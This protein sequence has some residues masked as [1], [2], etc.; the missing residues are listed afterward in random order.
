MRR[1][2]PALMP[3]EAVVEPAVGFTATGPQL[4]PARAAQRALF[5][6]A[7]SQ[8]GRTV[9]VAGKDLVVQQKVFVDDGDLPVGS[10]VSGSPSAL[11]G[12]DL[13][14]ASVARYSGGGVTYLVALLA[15]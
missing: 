13:L 5:D 1:I 7:G 14:V 12:V 6:G 4:G 15:S 10:R 9:Q 2:P 3:H 8:L 11:P